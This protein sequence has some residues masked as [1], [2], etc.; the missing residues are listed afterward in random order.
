MEEERKREK[1]EEE[2][3]RGKG[4]WGERAGERAG[5]EGEENNLHYQHNNED[6]KEGIKSRVGCL[7][8]DTQNS[9][10]KYTCNRNKE[11]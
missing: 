10:S 9:C 6:D 3:G 2:K 5:F 8:R 4:R 11:A 1:G 7:D